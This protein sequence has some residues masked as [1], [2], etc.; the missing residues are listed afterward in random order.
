MKLNTSQAIG[1]RE[2]TQYLTSALYKNIYQAGS[3]PETG[4]SGVGNRGYQPLRV[5]IVKKLEKCSDIQ[6]FPHTTQRPEV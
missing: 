2:F 5:D 4:D 3:I 1:L 6:S